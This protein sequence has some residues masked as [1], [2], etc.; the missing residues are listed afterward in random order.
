V[1][2]ED[3]R[4]ARDVASRLRTGRVSIRSRSDSFVPFGGCKQSGNGRECADRALRDFPD[5][6]RILRCG[7]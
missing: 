7:T 1:Q 6:K 4:Q 2:A 3:I 5:V